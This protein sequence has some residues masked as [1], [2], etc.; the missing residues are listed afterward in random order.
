MAPSSEIIL[1]VEEIDFN[2]LNNSDIK[3]Y[4]SYSSRP[5][6]EVNEFQI[7]N[8]KMLLQIPLSNF[9]GY[10]GGLDNDYRYRVLIQLNQ[11]SLESLKKIEKIFSEKNPDV[12]MTSAI[13]NKTMECY[14]SYITKYLLNGKD[15]H[16][17]VVNN[18]ILKNNVATFVIKPKFEIFRYS[19]KIIKCN[20][21]F[22]VI[23][24]ELLK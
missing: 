15:T 2:N 23:R 1:N 16:C 10:E 7:N 22:D 19:N 3:S 14:T 6:Y 12:V 20:L 11:K 18:D 21:V 4:V 9:I 17:F 24:C 13:A 5:E 8:K